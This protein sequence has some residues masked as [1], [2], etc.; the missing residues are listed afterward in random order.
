MTARHKTERA[1]AARALPA[2]QR[3]S[4]LVSVQSRLQ[5]SELRQKQLVDFTKRLDSNI[6]KS[7]RDAETRGIPVDEQ[8]R[9]KPDI[10]RKTRS[11]FLRPGLARFYLSSLTES[12]SGPDASKP[13]RT[14]ER[15]QR[16]RTRP[17]NLPGSNGSIISAQINREHAFIAYFTRRL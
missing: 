12:G 10:P 11:I 3:C 17:R 5:S 6:G 7:C 9:G 4:A 15:N 14:P 8:T 16:R 1:L 2:V 13:A